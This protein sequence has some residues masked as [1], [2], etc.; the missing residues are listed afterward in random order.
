MR[1]VSVR[2]ILMVACASALSCQMQFERSPSTLDVP[3]VL[4]IRLDPPESAVSQSVRATALVAGPDG[5]IDSAGTW[6]LCKQRPLVADYNSVADGCLDGTSVTQ[7]GTSASLDILVPKDACATFGSEPPSASGNEPPVRAFD[8]DV[9]G[10]YYQPLGVTVGSTQ[11]IGG[12]RLSCALFQANAETARAYRERYTANQNPVLR[13]VIFPETLARGQ[14]VTLRVQVDQAESYVV[15][16]S[17]RSQL[18]AR[19][20]RLSVSWFTTKGILRDALTPVESEAINVYTAPSDTT[21]V[22]MFVVLRDDR[23]GVAYEAR[24][25]E[26]R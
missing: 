4:A 13:E 16:D 14:T 6:S 1:N 15:Y 3:R 20:E 2:E 17:A 26:V 7:L 22:H 12:I 9:T 19:T 10:G 21:T 18:R 5:R 25:I 24:T 8:P 23:G 11:G